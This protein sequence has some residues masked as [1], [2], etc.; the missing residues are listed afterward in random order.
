MRRLILLTCIVGL[1][2]INVLL[3]IYFN[4]II[5]P[6]LWPQPGIF[7]VVGGIVLAIWLREFLSSIWILRIVGLC[8]IFIGQSYFVH[9]FQVSLQERSVI[10]FIHLVG[11][12][13]T[14]FVMMLSYINQIMP[15]N[16]RHAPAL[17]ASLPYIAAVIPT[18]GE[19]Y[20]VLE[21]TILSIKQ[22]DYPA[23]RLYIL[24]SDDGHREEIRELAALH[25]VHYNPGP[26]KDAKAGN[27]NAAL[28]YLEKH[29]PYAT[30]ILTQD[31]DELIHPLFLRKTVGYFYAGDPNVAFV[32]TPKEALTP[33]G[34]PFGNRDRVFYDIIQPGRNGAGAAFSCGSGVLWRISAVRSIGGYVTWNLV[35]DMTTSYHLHSAGYTSAYH[36][37]V[38]TIGL[39]PEDIPGML[40]QRGT[41]S[42]DTWRM[43]LFDNPLVRPGLNWRQRLQYLELGLFYVSSTVFTPL[44]LLTPLLSLATGDFLPIEGA[45][46]FPWMFISVLY[47]LSL[48]QGHVTFLIRMW[49]Y[50]IGHWPTYSHAFWIAVRSRKKKPVYKV[51]R[52]TRQNGFYGHM[53]WQ[54]FLYIIV[55]LCLSIYALFWMP[56]AAMSARLTNVGIL[57]FYMFMVSG[58]CRAAFFG[59]E[60]FSLRRLDLYLR[61]SLKRSMTILLQVL[62]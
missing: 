27:L 39:S 12:T 28:A 52:K 3:Q 54:Q 23:Q 33:P 48:S 1:F 59:I 62:Q 41:W 45:V 61:M 26:R 42:A 18:Y 15:Q 30:L 49:Q 21:R 2:A 14:F 11:F 38:L 51:T 44:I 32:Q 50:W 29:C 40:K 36:N 17:P 20:D 37:E 16:S 55:G 31:A 56:D 35:E 5:W 4:P 19:P 7:I 13:G 46:L 34:D 25:Q 10:G 6:S 22:L 8:M 58:I 47:Y 43:F 57:L 9:S 24:I 53:L 60:M